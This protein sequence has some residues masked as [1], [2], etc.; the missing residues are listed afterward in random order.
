MN[1][2]SSALLKTL[3]MELP[4]QVRPKP[5]P[6][7]PEGDEENC[8]V[9]GYLR[10]IRDRALHLQFRLHTGDT[11]SF[12][13]SW[14]GQVTHNR[15]S[16]IILTF[17]GDKTFKVTIEGRNLSAVVPEKIDLLNSGILRHRVVWLREMDRE[18]C[19]HLPDDAVAVE[20]ITIEAEE[21]D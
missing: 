17:V 18:E 15:S 2:R 20:R 7:E 11:E 19:N 6:V 13:Y 9:F 1:D 16:G 8:V 12:P 4:T 5:P 3:G 14:L 21:K 10:G